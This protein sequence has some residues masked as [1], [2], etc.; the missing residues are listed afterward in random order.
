MII[1][2][3]VNLRRCSEKQVF[4]RIL[5]NLQENICARVSFLVKL[6]AEKF[7]KTPV[8]EFCFHL[9]NFKLFKILKYLNLCVDI[10]T[11]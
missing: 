3:E 10:L 8:L 6:N 9:S 11:V 7:E 2:W 5:Q 1:S 4:L